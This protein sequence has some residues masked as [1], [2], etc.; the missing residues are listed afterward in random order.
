MSKPKSAPVAQD[1]QSELQNGDS[2][3]MTNHPRQAA[4][5][6]PEI[7]TRYL[8]EEGEPLTLAEEIVDEAERSGEDTYDQ[9]EKIKQGDIHIA[10]LQKMSM[11][12]LIE[13]ARKENLKDVSG[14]KKQDLIF[15]ILKGARQDER[16]D[17]RGRNPGNSARRFWFFYGV[18]TTTT[19]RA[20][21][22]FMSP[23]VRSAGLD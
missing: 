21:M 13:E 16:A 22:T 5:E 9:Y 12:Q 4:L 15:K 2:D 6:S 1:P 10:E 20:R 7:D 19:C 3:P 14:M 23:P 8:E 18:P 11:A 17:V